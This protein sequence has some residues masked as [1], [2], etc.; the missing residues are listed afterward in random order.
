MNKPTCAAIEMHLMKTV[1]WLVLGLLSLSVLPPSTTAAIGFKD[2]SEQSGI[3][4]LVQT[5]GS[6]SGGC[7]Q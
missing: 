6:A 4:R 3:V 7:E 5:A 2:V 1:T